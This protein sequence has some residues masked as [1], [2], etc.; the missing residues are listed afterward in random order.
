MKVRM[1]FV[2]NSSS[3]SFCLVGIC[4]DHEDHD[5]DDIETKA[6]AASLT[7]E[8]GPPDSVCG[9]VGL[10]PSKCRDDQTWGNFKQEILDKINAA[11]GTDFEK[12]YLECEG[13]Y[14]G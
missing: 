2:S 1:G 13:W 5:L 9:Y 4:F 6:G 3:S 11:F 7:Y 14:D 12:V 10:S 8:S